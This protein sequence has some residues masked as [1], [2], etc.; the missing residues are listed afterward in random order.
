MIAAR[1]RW[2]ELD[3][4]NRLPEIIKGVEF[5]DGLRQLQTAGY[6]GVTNFRRYRLSV[7]RSGIRAQPERRISLVSAPA[8]L[9]HH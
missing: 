8:M 7:N 3:G 6:S 1:G 9:R 5:Y 2:G 4:R